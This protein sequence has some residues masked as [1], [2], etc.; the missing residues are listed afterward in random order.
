MKAAELMI[1]GWYRRTNGSLFEVVAIDDHEATIELQHFDGTLDE[2]DMETWPTLLIEK[3]G[4][5]EDWS[6]SIDM[7]PEDYTGEDNGEM[8]LGWHD[9]L[10]VF[11][12]ADRDER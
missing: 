3:V 12:I 6:G 1:G 10:E 2:V 4:A 9:P 7:D 5:P 8:P 11:D